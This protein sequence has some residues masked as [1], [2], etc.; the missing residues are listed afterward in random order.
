MLPNCYRKVLFWSTRNE[1]EWVLRRRQLEIIKNCRKTPKT[2]YR[3]RRLRDGSREARVPR[4]NE[5]APV[6]DPG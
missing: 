1:F 4:V 5:E 6:P 3:Q 2:C